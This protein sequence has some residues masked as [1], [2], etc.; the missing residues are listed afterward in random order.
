MVT[1]AHVMD[2]YLVGP[3]PATA[4]RL[5]ARYYLDQTILELEKERIFFRSWLLAGHVS[6]LPRPGSYFTVDMLC[7]RLF[8][9]R[10]EDNELR[11]F[12]NVC[13]HRAH[14]L[15][16]G[17]GCKSALTCPYHAWTYALDGRLRHA[18]NSN[19]VEGFD[20]A[21]Y[22]LVPVRVEQFLGF[23][24]FNLDPDAESFEVLAP[25]L[26]AEIRQYVPRLDDL[27]PV[28]QEGPSEATLRCNWKIA[29][30][31][32]IECYHCGPAHPAF[33]DLVD[34][35]TYRITCHRMHTTHVMLSTKPCNAAYQYEPLNAGRYA[36]FWH[37][38]PNLDFGVM[39]GSPN[40][41]IFAIDPVSLD[42]EG[43]PRIHAHCAH[44]L[45]SSGNVLA[46]FL[47]SNFVT[48]KQ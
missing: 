45:M 29:L 27:V 2:D 11:G 6:Q 42:A 12:Y 3:D 41:G 40:L 26:E 31:N 19:M 37:V 47:N 38:W 44:E 7:E 1:D 4:W 46:A 24:L 14:Q 43:S 15:V 23:L 9:V 22:S 13:R 8:F 5:P 20:P 34:L 36:V 17:S 30:D 35:D 10:G 32:S 16:E 18:R 48:D 28:Q 21:H 33:V 39:P 25:E